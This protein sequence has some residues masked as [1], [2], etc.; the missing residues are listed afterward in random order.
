MWKK[1][2][3]WH[4]TNLKVKSLWS[5]RNLKSLV[6]K[7]KVSFQWKKLRL[8]LSGGLALCAIVWCIK[9]D[10]FGLNHH[11]KVNHREIKQSL[12]ITHIHK[13][14][15]LESRTLMWCLKHFLKGDSFFY[16]LVIISLK[17]S[18]TLSPAPSF[19]LLDSNPLFCDME[20]YTFTLKA[21]HFHAKARKDGEVGHVKAENVDERRAKWTW[22]VGKWLFMCMSESANNRNGFQKRW[23]KWEEQ[24][25]ISQLAMTGAG[26]HLDLHLFDKKM[27]QTYLKNWVS[28]K[29]SVLF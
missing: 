28:K 22:S 25:S 16:F 17:L 6:K 13:K 7:A 21:C 14:C 4:K 18:V 1:V 19:P 27:H 8:D 9:C 2:W 10:S 26:R 20:H 15:A 24:R 11:F 5:H 29:H 12:H 3:L 23:V